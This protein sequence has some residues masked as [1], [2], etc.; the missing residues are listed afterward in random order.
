MVSSIL[1]SAIIHQ[2]ALLS[3]DLEASRDFYE[4]LLGANFIAEFSPPGIAFF[5]FGD[6]R[7]LLDKNG[8]PGNIY[9]R[10]DDIEKSVN[11]LTEQGVKFETE[12]EA[13]FKDDDGLFGKAGDTEFMAFIEDPSSN[14]IALVEQKL[15]E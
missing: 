6:T 1:N 10:V 3:N 2:V 4:N 15:A 8:K 5:K 12:I 13:V 7:L 9:F 14:L 11:Q